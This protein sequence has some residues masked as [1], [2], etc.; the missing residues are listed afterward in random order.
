MWESWVSAVTL[1]S[2]KLGKVRDCVYVRERET[3][4][5]FLAWFYIKL[6]VFCSDHL[7][8]HFRFLLVP[9]IGLWFDYS[10]D[11][12]SADRDL[13]NPEVS[14]RIGMDVI[15]L[16]ETAVLTLNILCLSTDAVRL[17]ACCCRGD[18]SGVRYGAYSVYSLQTCGENPPRKRAHVCITYSDSQSTHAHLLRGARAL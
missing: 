8:Y 7:A 6:S 2:I 15:A 5:K 16:P 4:G 13:Q 11:H 17:E 10:R 1:G 12:R 18:V 3:L 14:G 9:G